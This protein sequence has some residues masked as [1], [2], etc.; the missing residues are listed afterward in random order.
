MSH[1]Y[2]LD[3]LKWDR[4]CLYGYQHALSES[5]SFR[6]FLCPVLNMW[7]TGGKTIWKQEGSVIRLWGFSLCWLER[8]FSLFLHSLTC[9]ASS[10]SAQISLLAFT[11]W[12]MRS[13]NACHTPK[14]QLRVIWGFHS[15]LNWCNMFC[16]NVEKTVQHWR[17]C[18][19]W[20]EF[21]LWEINSY[22]YFMTI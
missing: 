3:L 4:A 2:P 20:K 10:R 22:G 14:K 7:P 17:K 18:P 21:N 8:S 5:I 15:K 19:T 13:S 11:K 12:L 9:S 16:T 1:A 6:V